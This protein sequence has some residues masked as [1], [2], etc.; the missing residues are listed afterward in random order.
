MLS[1][2]GIVDPISVIVAELLAV[3][4]VMSLRGVVVPRAAPFAIFVVALVSSSQ[5]ISVPPAFFSDHFVQALEAPVSLL[6]RV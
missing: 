5:N 2:L 6:A 4:V 3:A 1:S